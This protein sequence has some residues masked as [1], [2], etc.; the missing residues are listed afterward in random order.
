MIFNQFISYSFVYSLLFHFFGDF[1]TTK[2]Q[3]AVNQIHC[4]RH[5]L[6]TQIVLLKKVGHENVN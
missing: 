2:N 1:A 3:N 5:F 4:H 6:P